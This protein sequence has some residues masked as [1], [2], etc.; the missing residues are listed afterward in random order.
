MYTK[1]PR[2]K[3]IICFLETSSR[4]CVTGSVTK[5]NLIYI[6][7]YIDVCKGRSVLRVTKNRFSYLTYYRCFINLLN[8]AIFFYVNR[9]NTVFFYGGRNDTAFFYGYGNETAFLSD[10]AF[11]YDYPFYN[12][13]LYDRSFYNNW[14]NFFHI[15]ITV[16]ILFLFFHHLWTRN[17]LLPCMR[18]VSRQYDWLGIL[19]PAAVPEMFQ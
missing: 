2:K 16:G 3:I 12:Y 9:D 7:C 8:T 6:F 14:C 5:C 11:F 19:S 13:R 4:P 15:D 1:T 17:K 10:R 18:E